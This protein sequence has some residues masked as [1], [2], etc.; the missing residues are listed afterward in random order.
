LEDKDCW[1]CYDNPNIEKHLIIWT[2]SNFYVALPKGPVT[3]DHLLIVTKKHI[4]SQVEIFKDPKLAEEFLEI[5]KKITDHLGSYLVFE[6][7]V[8]FK[9]SKAEHFNL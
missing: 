3:D 5:K 8:P 1:F 2:T 4:S 9:F 6:R 7:Y